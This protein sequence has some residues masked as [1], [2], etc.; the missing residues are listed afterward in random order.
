VWPA[1]LLFVTLAQRLTRDLYICC[2]NGLTESVPNRTMIGLLH[3][4]PRRERVPCAPGIFLRAGLRLGVHPAKAIES[5]RAKL[6]AFLVGPR[7]DRS[8]SGTPRKCRP[9]RIYGGKGKAVG[10][11]ARRLCC[12]DQTACVHAVFINNARL[13]LTV[14]RIKREG[15]PS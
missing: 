7:E 11:D 10:V 6:Y 5:E 12:P 8:G 9:K 14:R 1:A 4:Q 15:V 2:R 13:F 3:D